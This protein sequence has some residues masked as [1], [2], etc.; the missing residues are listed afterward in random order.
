MIVRLALES[1]RA[2]L[3][4]LGRRMTADHTPHLV[5][6]EARANATIDRYFSEAH[7]TFFVAELDGE[8]VGFLAATITDYM[9]HAGFFVGQQ[10]FYVRPDKRGTRAAASLFTVFNRWADS[11]NPE[12]VFAGIA[13]GHRPEVA[14]RWMRRFGFEL[15][16]PSMCRRPGGQLDGSV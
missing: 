3:L 14:A 5:F 7:P 1:D 16:G 15:A 2:V 9:A 12:E 6:D 11:L 10:L 8:V 13:T 4:E